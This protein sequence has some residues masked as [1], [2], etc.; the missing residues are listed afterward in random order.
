M[1]KK[2][3]SSAFTIPCIVGLL[4]FAKTLGDLCARIN[5]MSFSI[6]KNLVFGESK[7]TILRLLIADKPMKRRIDVLHDVV[8]KVES[9]IFSSDFVILDNDVNFEVHI[10]IGILFVHTGYSLVDIKKGT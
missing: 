10:I 1:R 9:F 3:D 6:C 7:P 4:H 8:V 5:V 2:E